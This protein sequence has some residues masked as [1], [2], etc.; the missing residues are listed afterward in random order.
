MKI[1]VIGA[2]IVGVSTAIWLQR[3]GHDVTLIDREGP[4]AGASFGNGGVLASCAV[5]PVTVPGLLAKAPGMLLSAEQPLYLKWG[6]LPRLA[7]WLIRYMRNA[8]DSS[9][10]ARARA[11][12]DIIGNSLADHQA[13]ARGT[14]AARFVVP[15]DYLYLYRDRAAFEADRYGWNLRAE[16]GITWDEIEGDDLKAIEP[17]Y[18]S[19][20]GFAVRMGDHGR[21]SDPG[22]YVSALAD[23][24]VDQGARFIKAEVTAVVRENGRVTGVRAGKETIACDAAVLATGVWSGPLA[25]S[26]GIKAPVESERGY[27][28]ELWGA[29]PMP[30]LPVMVAHAKFVATPMEGRLRLAGIVEFGGL[31]AP[32]SRK[33]FDLLETNIR[34][35]IPGITWERKEE[36]MGHRPSIVDSLPL[37]GEAPKA[38]GAW[39][40]FGHDHVGLTGGPK[41]GRLLAQLISGRRPNIDLAPFDPA[42]FQ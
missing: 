5:V 18:G 8:N 35:A 19:D 36:W 13:L 34:S 14:P 30:R 22:A 32:P 31:D 24:A 10:R 2:G 16:N 40:G 25:Q 9:T 39:L 33:P 26:L 20:L 42:R 38:K 41:T 15:T 28:L 11:M 7:P 21:I 37:I 6:Y 29:D 17:A 12:A 4:A 23:H 27:H 3:D 1:S